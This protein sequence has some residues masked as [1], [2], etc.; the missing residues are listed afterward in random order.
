MSES[1]QSVHKAS[2][3]L[4]DICKRKLHMPTHWEQLIT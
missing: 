2:F 1:Q 4:N 3:H